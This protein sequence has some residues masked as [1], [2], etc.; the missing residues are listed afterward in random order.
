MSIEDRISKLENSYNIITGEINKINTSITNINNKFN[1]FDK[2]NEKLDKIIDVFENKFMKNDNNKSLAHKG[3]PF[4]DAAKEN[5][6]E[7]I[8][9]ENEEKNEINR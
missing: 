2:Y 5:E 3:N 7:V 6:N 1:E 8:Y 4:Y 9:S